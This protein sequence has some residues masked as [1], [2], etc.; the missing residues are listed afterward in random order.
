MEEQRIAV[1]V[2]EAGKLVGVGRTLAY[3]LAATGEWPVIRIGRSVRVPVEGLKRWVERRT[4]PG[5][6]G[7]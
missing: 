3:S 6:S 7:R 2:P 1:S 5:V 4:E